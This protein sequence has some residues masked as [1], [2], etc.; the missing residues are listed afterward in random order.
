MQKSDKKQKVSAEVSLPFADALKPY[1]TENGPSVC[2][3][4]QITFNGNFICHY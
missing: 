1:L 2:R 3:S 4:T